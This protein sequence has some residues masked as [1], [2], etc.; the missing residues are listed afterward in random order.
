VALPLFTPDVLTAAKLN[1]LV[2][3]LNRAPSSTVNGASTGAAG[4]ATATSVIG[5]AVA[6]DANRAYKVSASVS[7]YSQS[8]ATDSFFVAFRDGGVE[9]PNANL[10]L[11]ANSTTNAQ[12][13]MLYADWTPSS[14][15]N[16]TV[17]LAC[18]RSTGTGTIVFG[19][20]QRLLLEPL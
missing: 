12:G 8:V 4:Y 17:D 13:F 11:R 19:G 3:E 9:I 7:Y 20:Y 5:L 15:G 1:V 18:T 6:V 14:G 2:T 16:H 10:L